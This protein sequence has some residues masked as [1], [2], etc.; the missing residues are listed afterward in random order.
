MKGRRPGDSTGALREGLLAL[1]PVTPDHYERYRREVQAMIERPM[2][3]RE[4]VGAVL[5]AAFASGSAVYFVVLALTHAGLPQLARFGLLAGAGLGVAWVCLMVRM[6]RRGTINRQSDANA[7]AAW[8]WLTAV[9]QGTLFAALGLATSGTGNGS[10]ALYGMLFLTM[11]A[12]GFLRNRIDQAE[13]T[14]RLKLLDLEL[15]LT[16][17]MS[18]Q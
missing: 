16:E 8:V 5:T 4:R 15:K 18:R 6:L 17:L 2:T 10:L 9:L 12:V 14:T 13:L 1:E 11:G 3:S 7:I